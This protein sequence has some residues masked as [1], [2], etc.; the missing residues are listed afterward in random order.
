MSSSTG[1]DNSLDS[2]TNVESADVCP[3]DTPYGQRVRNFREELGLSLRSVAR[4][5]GIHPTY[6]S[7]IELGHLPPPAPAVLARIDSALTAM[8]EDRLVSERKRLD[9]QRRTVFQHELLLIARFVEKYQTDSLFREALLYEFRNILAR[10]EQVRRPAFDSIP[11]EQKMSVISER[12]AGWSVSSL[13]EA[14]G[15]SRLR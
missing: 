10:L 5:A 7:K 8:L 11:G 15:S 2:V 14:Q 13:A 9:A 4:R 3:A 12:P 1:D 6:L